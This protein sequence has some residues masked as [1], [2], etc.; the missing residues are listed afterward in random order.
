LQEEDK[1]V[2]IENP[3]IG[4]CP[5]RHKSKRRFKTINEKVRTTYKSSTKKVL[6]ESLFVQKKRP[7]L[8]NFKTNSLMR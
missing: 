4:I 6:N 7:I 3:E 5:G 1:T 8:A 2:R